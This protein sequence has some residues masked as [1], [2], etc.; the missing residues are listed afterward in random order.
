MTVHFSI[1]ANARMRVVRN[2][3]RL[4]CKNFPAGTHAVEID[5]GESPAKIVSYLLLDGAPG[6]VCMGSQTYSAFDIGKHLL[7]KC[8]ALQ[9][10]AKFATKRRLLK[11]AIAMFERCV[12]ESARLLA[13]TYSEL[14]S[15]HLA[16]RSR[17]ANRRK[18]LIEAIAA[19]ECAATFWHNVVHDQRAERN[20]RVELSLLYMCFPDYRQALDQA[21]T[22]LEIERKLEPPDAQSSYVYTT[23]A[24]AYWHRGSQGAAHS[25][26]V[27]GAG[28]SQDDVAAL[29][30]LLSARWQLQL[31][32]GDTIDTNTHG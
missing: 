2:G 17:G 20:T 18:H 28:R 15:A 29:V 8:K 27:E 23:A 12:P 19:R 24:L 7:A 4:W 13:E 14:S 31:G 6:E 25:V 11:R 21:L 3:R 32:R 5:P 10:G 30:R 9:D 22:A 16:V 26:L 1:G